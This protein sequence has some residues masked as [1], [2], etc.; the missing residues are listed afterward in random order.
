MLIRQVNRSSQAVEIQ[1]HRAVS[2]SGNA[3]ALK[4]MSDVFTACDASWRGFGV[5]PASGL[6]LRKEYMKFDIE[7]MM[8]LNINCSADNILCI[9]GDILRGL[10][11]PPDC[12]LFSKKCVP[13]N[14]SGACMVSSEGTCNT[15]YKYKN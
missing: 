3:I 5:I 15:W 2:E 12:P 11:T 6:V 10:K 14:P 9:C 1:Y 4:S 13:E 8:P 7:V